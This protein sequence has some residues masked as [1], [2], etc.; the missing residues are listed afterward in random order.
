MDTKRVM[1]SYSRKDE[2]YAR[3]IES[4]FA[5]THVTILRDKTVIQIGQ[6]WLERIL[7]EIKTSD[8][9]LLI[10]S[11]DSVSSEYVALEAIYANLVAG[12]SQKKAFILPI[13]IKNCV[14]PKWLDKYQQ[15]NFVDHPDEA[16]KSLLKALGFPST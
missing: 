12:I 15:A 3:L 2:I 7:E 5:S 13:L 8:H 9:L 14:P 10:L 1:L 16:A 11:P 4:A 6:D